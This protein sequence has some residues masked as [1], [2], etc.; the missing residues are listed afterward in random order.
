MH[1]MFGRNA[2]LRHATY[3]VRAALPKRY[4]IPK[5]EFIEM[6]YGQSVCQNIYQNVRNVAFVA[7]TYRFIRNRHGYNLF[8][9]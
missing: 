8:T 7:K 9:L 1:S 5:N 4:F 2:A 6:H 3:P